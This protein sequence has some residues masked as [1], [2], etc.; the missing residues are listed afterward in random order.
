MLRNDDMVVEALGGVK[1][2]RGG[3][4]LEDLEEL[5]GEEEG[6]QDENLV[7]RRKEGAKREETSR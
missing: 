6:I 5:E 7:K 2:G 1:R 3:E 4:D